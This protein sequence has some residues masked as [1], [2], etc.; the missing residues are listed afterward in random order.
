MKIRAA[1]TYDTGAPYKI[2]DVELDVPK[3]GEILVRITASGIF[4]TD[5][6]VQNQFIPTPLPAVLGHEGAGIVEAV[7]P[8]VTEFKIG[9]HVGISF[10]FCNSCCNCR[11]ARPFACKKLNAIN[12]GGIQPDGTTRLHTLDGK[13]LSTFF[14]QSSFANY[15]VVN[16]NHAVKVPYDDMDL[17][18]VAPMGCGIQTG[19]GAVLNRLRPEFGSSIAIFGAALSV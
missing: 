5:E 9:D 17:A 19:A 8:G 12:F 6:A 16:Q 4:H 10:G 1:V 13:K 18:L 3:F 11:K 7:G 2:E 15:A 14:G